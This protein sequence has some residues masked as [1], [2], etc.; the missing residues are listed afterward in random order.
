[1]SWPVAFTL[2][3]IVSPTD[4]LAATVIARRLGAPRRVITLIEGE[5]LANDATA[6]V[7]YRIAVGAA[8]GAGV[9]AWQVVSQFVL[10]IAGGVVTGLVVGW[11]AT[12][13]RRR[14]DD[15]VL[16]TSL[17]LVTAYLAYLPAQWLG[18]SGVLGAVTA[19][20]YVGWQAPA[21]TSAP[22][23]LV[24]TAFW[25]VLSY[26]LN[27]L[28]FVLVGSQLHPILT[29]VSGLPIT[30]LIQVA[31]LVSA[32]VIGVRIGW[33]FTVPYLAL[34]LDPRPGRRARL[35]D[36]GQRLV[37]AWSGMRGAVSLAVALALPTE[38]ATGRP[39]PERD[40]IVFV[41][42]GVI[43]TTLVLP[44][45]TLP[46]LIRLLGLR[47]VGAAEREE[48]QARLATTEAAFQRLEELA[49][50]EWPPEDTV[51]RLK[52]LLQSRRRR[53][54]AQAGLV[55]ERALDDHPD[56]YRQLISELID[57]QR[58][59]I[60]ELRNRGAISSGVLHRVERDLDLEESRLDI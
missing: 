37:V 10:G 43:F 18:V 60:V 23:R 57:A 50:E 20:L 58:R 4:P 30:M 24:G 35:L 22:T 14:V 1:M 36:A 45:L 52:H 9:T 11:L 39:F 40:L 21:V 29:G 6:L 47:D 51:E 56:A 32:V 13:V 42:F 19:G 33:H 3:A 27:A 7:A 2:G 59:A 5:G 15:P 44:G 25:E 41:A 49:A 34:A 12:Q 55:G 26:L 31:L 48:A 16:E 53:L 8:L 54:R 28:L 17:A 46:A 38:T